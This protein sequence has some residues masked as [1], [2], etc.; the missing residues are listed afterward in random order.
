MCAEASLLRRLSPGDG[1]ARGPLHARLVYGQPFR[2]LA[3]AA[4]ELG[5]P[6]AP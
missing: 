4:A 3:R 1:R 6:S 2:P 5:S